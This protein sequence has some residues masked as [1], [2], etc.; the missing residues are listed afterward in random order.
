MFILGIQLYGKN[1]KKI[2]ALIGS[3]NGAQIRSHAQK[4]FIKLKK[5]YDPAEESSK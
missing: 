2:E 1:W 5:E 3:R 4:F